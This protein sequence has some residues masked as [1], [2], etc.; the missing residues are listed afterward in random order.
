MAITARNTTTPDSADLRITVS[1]ADG[2]QE[3]K[4]AAYEL[5]ARSRYTRMAFI[6]EA[7]RVGVHEWDFHAEY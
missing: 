2:E 4:V 5:L 3:A 6:Y 1:G 7:K